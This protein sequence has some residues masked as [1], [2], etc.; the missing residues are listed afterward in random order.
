MK[1]TALR[2]RAGSRLGPRDPPRR[3]GAVMAGELAPSDPGVDAG[4]GDGAGVGSLCR[5]LDDSTVGLAIMLVER[6]G[7]LERLEAWSAGACRRPGGAPSCSTKKALLV[8]VSG[9]CTHRSTPGLDTR[10]R[11]DVPAVHLADRRHDH[12]HRG[13]ARTRRRP[14]LGRLLPHRAL[15]LRGDC[16]AD[17]S[18]AVP[19]ESPA[20]PPVVSHEERRP[21]G[22]SDPKKNSTSPMPGSNGS[23]T[24]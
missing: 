10:T 4:A 15:S 8:A 18:L 9:V 7:V 13:P 1:Y 2:R 6:T 14:R 22:R 12:R 24:R 23:R 16:Q 19:E 17:G 3:R 11:C 20:R 5:T 21:S